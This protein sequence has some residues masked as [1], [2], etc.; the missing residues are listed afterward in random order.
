[1]HP[2]R[3]MQVASSTCMVRRMTDLADPTRR[4]LLDLPPK[5]GLHRKAPRASLSGVALRGR[6]LFLATDEGTVIDRLTMIDA[7][8][9]A[10]P[11]AFPLLGLLDLPNRTGKDDEIDIEGIDIDGDLL[12]LVGSHTWTRGKP[13]DDPLADLEK[14]KPNPNRGVLACLPLLPAGD[15]L[16]SLPE[17]GSDAPYPPAEGIARLP[18]G[19]KRGALE[20]ALKKDRHLKSFIGVPSKENG[21][22][23]EGM[24]VDGRRIFLGLR[25]PVLRGFALVLEI[26]VE[27]GKPG[28]L[29]LKPV[30]P[31]GCRY[32][33]HFLDLG[34]NGVR[35]LHRDGADLLILAGPTVDIDGRCAIWRWRDALAMG[36]DSFTTRGSRLERLLRIPVGNDDDHPEGFSLLERGGREVLVVYDTPAKGRCTGKGA[37]HADLFQLPHP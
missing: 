32:R 10:E 28:E 36:K 3:K 9:F 17:A 16:W 6:S 26:E 18:I 23:V 21:F 13:K 34:G 2:G 11:R 7:G 8:R 33:K 30:G 5:G 12:W 15:G 31:D 24:A 29:A 1:M 35:D 14:V 4:V 19:K 20:K 37:V 27:D 25:G 22:D